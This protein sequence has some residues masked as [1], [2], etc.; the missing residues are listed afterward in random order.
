MAGVQQ[1]LVIRVSPN[2]SLPACDKQHR[3]GYPPDVPCPRKIPAVSYTGQSL[4]IEIQATF[5]FAQTCITGFGTSPSSIT[6]SGMPQYCGIPAGSYHNGE[7]QEP[8]NARRPPPESNLVTL[9]SGG[10]TVNWSVLTRPQAAYPVPENFRQ[11]TQWQN[12]GFRT[13]PSIC[14]E[15]FPHRQLPLIIMKCSVEPLPACT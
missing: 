10:D 1:R 11:L 13:S 5:D 14:S 8:Q 6:P 2:R 9:K 15:M 12:R 7:P 4:G 3:C